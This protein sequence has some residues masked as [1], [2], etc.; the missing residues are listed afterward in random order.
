MREGES[1]RGGGCAERGVGVAARWG[2]E[3]PR[4]GR[5]RDG[6]QAER[7]IARSPVAQ[8]VCVQ[9]QTTSL[10]AREGTHLIPL[11]VRARG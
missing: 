5:A 10:G 8:R 1:E 9:P 4:S 3:E 11:S 7:D 6:G 2:L